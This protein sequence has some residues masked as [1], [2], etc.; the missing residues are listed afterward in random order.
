MPHSAAIGHACTRWEGQRGRGMREQADQT[1]QGSACT[2]KKIHILSQE[3]QVEGGKRRRAREDQKEKAQPIAS[4]VT[5]TQDFEST[6]H[7]PPNRQDTAREDA[8][9]L[10]ARGNVN[11][12]RLLSSSFEAWT[13]TMAGKRKQRREHRQSANP[14]R[15]QMSSSLAR[16]SLPPSEHGC[17]ALNPAARSTSAVIKRT[18]AALQDCK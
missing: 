16:S 2:P 12:A 15:A 6:G 18:Q 9:A 14:R 10:K 3:M 7:T 17:H 1:G 4:A 5:K 11:G 8:E 13:K